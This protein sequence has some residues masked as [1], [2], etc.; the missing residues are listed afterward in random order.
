MIFRTMNLR[1]RSRDRF[2]I[3]LRFEISTVKN[4]V[5]NALP[6]FDVG[7]YSTRPDRMNAKQKEIRI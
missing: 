1:D 6:K 2:A 7:R 5:S 3:V 4:F